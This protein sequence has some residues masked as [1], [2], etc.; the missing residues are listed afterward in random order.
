[1]SRVAQLH[2]LVLYIMYSCNTNILLGYLVTTSYMTK[3]I[4]RTLPNTTLSEFEIWIC[5]L[6]K[7]VLLFMTF[8]FA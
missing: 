1:M 3:C 7:N 6:G 2:K 4:N 8:L 5:V